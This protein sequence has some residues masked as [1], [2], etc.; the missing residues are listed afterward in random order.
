MKRLGVLADNEETLTRGDAQQE[1]GGA[2]VAVGHPDVFGS[3]QGKNLPQQGP[4]L[5]MTVLTRDDV[6]DQAPLR[7]VHR[8]HL[9]GQGAGAERA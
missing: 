9:T 6:G 8:Q 2:E 7:V 3:D 1:A 5:G 4:L